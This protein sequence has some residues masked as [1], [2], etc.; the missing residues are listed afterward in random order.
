MFGIGSTE[1]LIICAVALIVLG[2]SKLPEILRTFGKGLA[3]FRKISGDV[4]STLDAEVRRAEDEDREKE[5][6]AKRK[7]EEAR[8]KAAEAT[9]KMP[10]D[11]A[12]PANPE[13]AEAAQS[14]DHELVE[15]IEDLPDDGLAGTAAK[16]DED[17]KA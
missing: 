1:L 5:R 13:T 12:A 2:P 16:A 4:K 15:E 9:P 6:E 8:E 3:E 14:V 10:A 11:D 17:S 7:R